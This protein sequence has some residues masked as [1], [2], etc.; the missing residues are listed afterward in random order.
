MRDFMR[1]VRARE[2]HKRARIIVGVGT[3]ST[4]K[5]LRWMAAH[6]PGVHVPDAVLARISSAPDQKA[7]GQRVLVETM[8]A[9]AE[10]EGVGG[11]HLM[12]HRNDA[13]LAEAIELSGLRART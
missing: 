12:G 10:I 13:V 1:E 7:E 6:V 8:Q 3:L 4:A 9:L 5:A 2:L 11:V